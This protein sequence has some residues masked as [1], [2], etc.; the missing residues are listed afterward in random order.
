MFP[1]SIVIPIYNEALRL[2]KTFRALKKG[3]SSHGFKVKEIIF[4]NDGSTD[5]TQ[6]IV[7]KWIAAKEISTPVRLLSYKQNKGK[8]YAI[9][10]GILSTHADYILCMDADMSTPLSQLKKM[11][12][13]LKQG[14]DIVIGT[15]KNGHS[16]VIKH[17]PIYRELLGRGFTLLSNVFLNTWITD[18][19]CGFKIFSRSAANQI[20]NRTQINRWGYDAE[21][22]FLATR[23]GFSINEV[24]VRWSH[25]EGS[26]VR[27]AVALPQTLTELFSIRIYQLTSSYNLPSKKQLYMKPALQWI[28]THLL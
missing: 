5:S 17:Q 2:D 27:L 28:T 8:G 13:P 24:A 15:R 6:K 26:K 1:L 3:F 22:L 25:D 20:A 4:V 23:L 18:F 16:T 21:I 10:K 11:I 14:A 9:R 12:T 19:T 7:K